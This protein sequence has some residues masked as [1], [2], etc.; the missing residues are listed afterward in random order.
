MVF[1]T[2]MPP[3]RS[4]VQL[5]FR[6]DP[7]GLGTRSCVYVF[8]LLK[9]LDTIGLE[10]L[11]CASYDALD[12]EIG[13]AAMEERVDSNLAGGVEDAGQDA[14]ALACLKGKA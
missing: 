4:Q 10:R 12:I 8:E 13:D 2:S 11:K 7:C 3:C 14:T 9:R 5:Q 1:K 6:D